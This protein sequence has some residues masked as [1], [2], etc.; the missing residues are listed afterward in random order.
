[1]TDPMKRFHTI[2]LCSLTLL[3]AMAGTTFKAADLSVVE[4]PP[5]PTPAQVK[6]AKQAFDQGT[7]VAMK[8]GTIANFEALLNV[9]M[10]RSDSRHRQPLP[11]VQAVRKLP[12]GQVR[13][14]MRKSRPFDALDQSACDASFQRWVVHQ[15][16][17]RD[18]DDSITNWTKIEDLTIGD[19][20]VASGYKMSM[21]V[22]VYRAN[23]V[24]LAS[25]Y[26]LCIYT[27]TLDLGSADPPPQLDQFILEVSA[28]Y[29]NGVNSPT[30]D[31]GP[32]TNSNSIAIGQAVPFDQNIPGPYTAS[33]LE[34]PYLAGL[35]PGP[36]WQYG[37]YQGDPPTEFRD[38]AIYQVPTGT[39]H[40][41]LSNTPIGVVLPYGSPPSDEVVITEPPTTLLVPVSAPSVLLPLET[42]AMLGAKGSFDVSLSSYLQTGVSSSPGWMP[43]S[44]IQF[45]D[46]NG[47]STVTPPFG[48]TSYTVS[49]N[50]PANPPC[51]NDG[52]CTNP[53]NFTLQTIPAYAAVQT[54]LPV[55]SVA[56]ID[57]VA[58]SPT[59]GV[60]IAGGQDWNGNILKTA[61]V[62]NSQ[63]ST[64]TTLTSQLVEA[65]YQHTATLVAPSSTCQAANA[66]CPTIGQVLIAGGYGANHQALSSTEFFN[67]ATTQFSQGPSMTSPHADAVAVQLQD[68]RILIMGGLDQSGSAT[69]VVDIYDPTTNTFSSTPMTL[70]QPRWNFA[71]NLLQ[72]GSVLVEGGSRGPSEYEG[73]ASSSAEKLDNCGSGFYPLPNGPQVPRQAQATTLLKNGQ[74]LIVG[75]YNGS[76]N[77]NQVELFTPSSSSFSQITSLASDR[78]Y[79]SLVLQED[80]DA[81][82]IGG[83][84]VANY[85]NIY[86]PSSQS[87]VDSL[88]TIM[89]EQRAFSTA[90]RLEGIGTADKGKIL[91][92]G[93]VIPQTG[94]SNGELVELYD[95]VVRSWTSAGMLSTS[96]MQHTVTLYGKYAGSL[97]ATFGCH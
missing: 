31:Y 79:S 81:A 14:F 32:Q 39:T 58:Q 63:T 40:L 16:L 17:L 73:P 9:A 64:V 80:G 94:S 71:A 50:V 86:E 26:Y 27:T 95:P 22:S 76:G 43:S 89:T 54:K 60:L 93:G 77:L 61:D 30:S 7:I 59:A 4:V 55:T 34:A 67:P 92:A 37:P 69:A 28:A 84:N 1:M 78:V 5:A 38:A 2:T 18:D 82:L 75:G 74:V 25:D 91:V 19:G 11:C 36:G 56:T 85:S 47:S 6:A 65:R 57:L 15:S 8:G 66:S 12:S 35:G 20:W 88:T 83:N 62:W 42:F 90:I 3:I 70:T 46:P 23:T 10:P 21:D 97:P 51:L 29:G 49:F 52:S 87:F 13:K 72:D 53:G 44:S 48:S 96:R 68:G 24:D 41:T 45:T 33:A